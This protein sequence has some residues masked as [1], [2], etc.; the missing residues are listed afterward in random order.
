MA[1]H[2]LQ[3]G[4]EMA[5]SACFDRAF[6]NRTIQIPELK[7]SDNKMFQVPECTVLGSPLS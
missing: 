1:L 6:N 7:M 3:T 5:W 4:L 2:H